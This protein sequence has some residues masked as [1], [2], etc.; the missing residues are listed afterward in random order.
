MG[1]AAYGKAAGD[2]N[3]S[4]RALDLFKMMV[5]YHTTPGLLPPK[6]NPETRRMKGLVMP[7]VFISTAQVLRESV[8][9]PICNEWIERS[10]DE[11]ERDFIKGDLKAIMETVNDDGSFLDTPEGRML[12]PGH[13]IELAW[14]ILHEAKLRNDARMKK[15]GLQI[16]DLMWEWGWDREYGGIIYYRDVKNLPCTEYWHDMKFWWPQNEAIIASLLAYQ[17]TG[18]DKYAKM[19]ALVHDWAYKHY[20]DREFGEWFG[21]LHRDGRISTDLKGNNWKGPF[22]LP[23]DAMVL[24]EVIEEM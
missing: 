24:L 7:M 8:N 12:C 21:Y 13:S 17:M 1:L 9:D 20:P 2:G 15:I 18:D 19:H 14:F 16:L 23:R 11:V 4:Q 22:H 10:V 3:A 6:W 5:R